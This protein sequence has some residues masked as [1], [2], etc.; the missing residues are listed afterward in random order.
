MVAPPTDSVRNGPPDS[1]DATGQIAPNILNF[2]RLLRGAGLPVGPARVLDAVQAVATVGVAHRPDFYWALHAVLVTR[3]EQHPI[4]D[5]AFKIYWLNPDLDDHPQGKRSEPESAADED[6]LEPLSRRLA[7][8]LRDAADTAPPDDEGERE[9]DAAMTWSAAD[10]FGQRDFE[11]MSAAEIEAAKRLIARLRLPVAEIKSR[12][13]A[14]DRS[15]TRID[16][17]RTLSRAV[18]EGGDIIPLAWRKPR[19]RRPPL[20]VLCDISGSMSR[21][22]RMFLHFL[23]VLSNGPVDVH[24]FVFGTQLTN[25][26]RHLARRDVDHALAQ[27]GQ[28]VTD[29]SGGTRIGACLHS[30]NRDWGR[31]VLAQGASVLLITDGLDRDGAVDLAGEAERLHNS[32][33]RLIWLNPLLRYDAYAPLALGAKALA[34]HVDDMRTIHNL[35]SMENLA[36]VLA[37]SVARRRHAIT[38]DAA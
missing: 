37:G 30:F 31:R 6:P 14:P 25:I 16:I 32:C 34:P 20:V 23:H 18:R 2:V 11:E 19:R 28:A 22:S 29:W 33:R 1:A 10:S 9:I 35:D 4:F 13:F 21:Y 3:H 8:A 38:E 15:G 27:I 36:S 7:D 24:A 5:Q 26:T 17:R 12:R